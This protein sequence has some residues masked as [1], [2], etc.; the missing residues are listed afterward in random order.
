L[1]GY[2]TLSSIAVAFI[3]TALLVVMVDQMTRI[4]KAILPFPDKVE[5]V[6]TYIVLT[7]I[8]SVVCWQGDFDLFRYL[9][10][11]WQYPW[12]GWL[13]TGTLIAGGSSLL[14]K[15]FRVVGLIPSVISGVASM[16]GYGGY[17]GGT[18]TET[19][20]DDGQPPI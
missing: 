5:S 16:F 14:V 15:Q 17:G 12:E 18:D 19:T 8:A 9:D 3:A 1:Y 4:I 10:F 6:I 20:T 13:L 2:G 7:G 11:T